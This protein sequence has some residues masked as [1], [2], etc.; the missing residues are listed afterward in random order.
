MDVQMSTVPTGNN[1]ASTATSKA[2][3]TETAAKDTF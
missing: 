1:A 2:S 3:A